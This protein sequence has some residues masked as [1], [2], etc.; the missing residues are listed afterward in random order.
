[1]VSIAG[2]APIPICD[3]P[4]I[5]RGGTWGPD[6]TIV[7]PPG[8]SGLMVVP[9]AGGRPQ[10][11]ASADPTMDNREH[12]WPQFLPDG[13]GL[14]S[15]VGPGLIVDGLPTLAV[16]SFKTR[17]WHMLGPGSQAQYLPSGYLVYHAPHVREGEL[18]AVPFD[19]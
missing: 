12:S 7:F 17:Q 10:P 8:S 6:G 11:L 19:P 16:L 3:A 5:G 2:G 14:L 9:A 15:T 13:Q 18:D 4:V 1:R